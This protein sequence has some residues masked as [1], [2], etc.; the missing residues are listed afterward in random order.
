MLERH[1]IFW[2]YLPDSCVDELIPLF[3][4][5]DYYDGDRFFTIQDGL[6]KVSVA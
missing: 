2:S 3:L 6:G 5:S 4:L 1:H